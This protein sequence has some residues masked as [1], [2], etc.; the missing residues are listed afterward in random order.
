M[1]MRFRT[2]AVLTASLALVAACSTAPVGQNGAGRLRNPFVDARAYVNPHW[3]AHVLLE[4]GGKRIA[5]TSTALWLDTISDIAPADPKRWGLAQYLDDALAQKADLITIVLYD[6]PNRDC[7]ALASSGELRIPEGGLARY[8]REYIDP[9]AHILSREKYRRLRI[10]AIIEPDSLPNLIT[11]LGVP[12]CRQAAGPGGYAEGVQYALNALYPLRNVYSYVDI[13]HAGWLGWDENLDKAAAL[14]A[15]VVRGTAHGTDSVAGF[16]SNTAN[17]DPL[18]EPY[19]EPYEL[20]RVPRDG[21]AFVRQAKF[22]GWNPRFGELD[23]ARA[24]REKML[25]QGFPDTTGMLIDTSRNGWGGPRRPRRLSGATDP[26]AFVDQSRIDRRTDRGMW[27]N[28]PGGIGE[29]PRA[30]PA[31]GIDAYVWVKPP[32][33]SDGVAQPGIPDPTDPAKAFDRFCDPAY[34]PRNDGGLLTGAMPGAPHAGR[35]FSAGFRVLLENA[36]PPLN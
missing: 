2:A 19:L 4:P 7:A 29:R 3:R 5:D 28:Q 22:Y 30:N 8:Q 13:G 33:E 34:A 11:N 36:W 35:W 21:G 6:L 17:Y 15:H 1:K 25:A 31:P 10:I 9:I 24:F 32:G 26:D 27:C 14:I 23:Y 20:A 18:S 12:K 16:I